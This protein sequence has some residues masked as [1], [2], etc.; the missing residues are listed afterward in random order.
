MCDYQGYHTE[1]SL[2][3]FCATVY[4]VLAANIQVTNTVLVN[5]LLALKPD[6]WMHNTIALIILCSARNVAFTFSK[7][8]QDKFVELFRDGASQGLR[9]GGQGVR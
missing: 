9:E 8:V 1:Q 2:V 5:A 7:L 6:F 3:K 4:S